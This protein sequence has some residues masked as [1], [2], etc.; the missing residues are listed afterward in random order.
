MVEQPVSSEI[1][2]NIIVSILKRFDIIT[3]LIN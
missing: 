1:E 3:Y 2:F